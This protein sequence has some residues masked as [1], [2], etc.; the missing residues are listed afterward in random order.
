MSDLLPLLHPTR[1]LPLWRCPRCGGRVQ[2]PGASRLVPLPREL[3]SRGAGAGARVLRMLGQGHGV[4]FPTPAAAAVHGFWLLSPHDWAVTPI[5][6]LAVA[7]RDYEAD[8]GG[9]RVRRG[10]VPSLAA[11]FGRAASCR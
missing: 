9:I 2:Q 3:G 10:A 8:H 6:P 7:G 11:A 1:P 4:S 5:R